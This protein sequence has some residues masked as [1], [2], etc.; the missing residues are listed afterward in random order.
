[1][2]DENTFDLDTI[3]GIIGLSVFVGCIYFAISNWTSTPAYK[4]YDE[5]KADEQCWKGVINSLVNTAVEDAADGA[6]DGDYY[7]D[8]KRIYDAIDGIIDE[9]LKYRISEH[10]NEKLKAIPPKYQRSIMK[11][12]RLEWY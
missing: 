6:L 9:N 5:C 1:M 11:N 7:W 12:F 8:R 4:E 2:K 3:K 10:M